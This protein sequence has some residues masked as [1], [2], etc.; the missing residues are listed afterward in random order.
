MGLT[1]QTLARVALIILL[2]VAGSAA[3][4]TPPA[5][6][7][8]RVF[9]QVKAKEGCL[10]LWGHEHENE[11]E[12][13]ASSSFSYTGT[14]CTA[15]QFVS[16][17]GTLFWKRTLDS[18]EDIL[19]FTGR[20]DNGVLDGSVK[21]TWDG[22]HTGDQVYVGGCPRWETEE[23][24]C[25]P[26]S[27]QLAAA[28]IA[29]TGAT[30]P[31]EE[32]ARAVEKASIVWTQTRDPRLSSKPVQTALPNGDTLPGST[33]IQC[34]V[35]QPRTG[36]NARSSLI[37]QCGEEVRLNYCLQYKNGQDNCSPMQTGWEATLWPMRA[38]QTLNMPGADT[39]KLWSV[40][41]CRAPLFPIYAVFK[42]G[43]LTD[44][45]C[46]EDGLAPPPAQPGQFPRI[47]RSND[48]S[49]WP[50]GA[51]NKKCIRL[52]PQ[53]D[54]QQQANLV[55]GCD[56]DLNVYVCQV[57]N[58]SRMANFACANGPLGV[59]VPRLVRSGW[60]IMLGAPNTYA[61]W[62]VFACDAPLVPDELHFDGN[63]MTGICKPP[64]GS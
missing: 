28:N 39:L 8:D 26:H 48:P 42:G 17:S 34:V 29:E 6:A 15:G 25:A 31:A 24:S 18:Q 7:A 3:F 5:A 61:A 43:M 59:A 19:G 2:L 46:A 40:F 51:T 53:L 44:G 57:S 55:Q 50:P 10:F 1:R 22:N 38:G 62:I 54:R 23:G 16:G 36:P 4:L 60:T 12:F 35:F 52:N 41:G 32:T 20:F 49:T 33:N 47:V 11:A 64:Y 21:E 58:G 13:R 14:G 56:N 45:L 37:N 27:G 63:E 9:T 30:S